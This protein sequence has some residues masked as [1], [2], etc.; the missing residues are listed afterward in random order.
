VT[1]KLYLN[2]RYVGEV[3]DCK[4]EMP[5][6]VDL[7][8]RCGE[9]FEDMVAYEGAGSVV[10]LRTKYGAD[11]I[12]YALKNGYIVP[13]RPV[14]YIVPDSS[15]LGGWLIH[16][17]DDQLSVRV[18]DDFFARVFVTEYFLG[19]RRK[20]RWVEEDGIAWAYEKLGPE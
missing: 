14:A 19:K 16:L 15:P 12:D 3:I 20:I 4:I 8:R 17:K 13:D 9:M 2:D 6:L 5:S 11:V 18:D 1:G 7:E 10:E